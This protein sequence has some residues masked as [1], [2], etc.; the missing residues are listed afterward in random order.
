MLMS[1]IMYVK[2]TDRYIIL[3]TSMLKQTKDTRFIKL[4]GLK[5]FDVSGQTK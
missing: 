5:H 2:E 4:K 3:D 1:V